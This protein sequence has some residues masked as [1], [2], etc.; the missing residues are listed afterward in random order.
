MWY[1]NTLIAT[2][3]FGNYVMLENNQVVLSASTD[4]GRMYRNFELAECPPCL[5]IAVADL[6]DT[7]A[8]DDHE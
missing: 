7:L 8:E 5:S 1:V 2:D 3:D 4:L 6:L